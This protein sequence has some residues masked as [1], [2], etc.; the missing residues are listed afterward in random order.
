MKPHEFTKGEIREQFIGHIR[1]MV[2][3]WEKEP[4]N[5]TAREKLEGLAFSILVA[6]DG[7]AMALPGWILAP[8][9]HPSDK[10]YHQDKGECWY[11]DNEV[12]E[13]VV[14]GDI[15]GGLHDNLFKDW[16]RVS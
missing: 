8:C 16:R 2:D 12:A 15:A 7:S 4:R 13:K 6:I 10:K 9:P 14:K 11:P 1:A 3:Y 5:P